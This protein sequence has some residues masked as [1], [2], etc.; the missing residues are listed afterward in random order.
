MSN[1]ELIK[2]FY[3]AFKNKDK[4]TYLGL[5]DDHIEWQLS[6]GMPNGGGFVG[7]DAVFKGYFPKILSNFKEF[8]TIP[9]YISDMKDHVMVTGKYQVISKK[10]NPLRH[11]FH[12]YIIS[13][14]TK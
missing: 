3:H 6:E 11:L 8:H 4:E 5:C 12:M 13:K 1:V 2:K 7:K 14:I 10:T 9:E